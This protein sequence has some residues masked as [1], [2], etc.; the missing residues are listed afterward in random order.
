MNVVM[1]HYSKSFELKSLNK[2][3]CS[4]NI[5]IN[6]Y[7]QLSFYF[8]NFSSYNHFMHFVK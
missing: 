8:N 6:L 4:L 3:F 2:S 1:S 7:K 5:A